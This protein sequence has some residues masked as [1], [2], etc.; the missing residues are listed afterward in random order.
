[1]PG[2]ISF[3]LAFGPLSDLP[4][5][6]HPDGAVIV[7]V[8][9][10]AVQTVVPLHRGVA[11]KL[12][13]RVAGQPLPKDAGVDALQGLGVGAHAVEH[14]PL[15]PGELV[16]HHAF[17]HGAAGVLAR[18]QVAEPAAAQIVDAD[19]VLA[20]AVV[21]QCLLVGVGGRVPGVD[22]VGVPLAGLVPEFRYLAVSFLIGEHLLKADEF[23]GEHRGDLGFHLAASLHGYLDGHGKEGTDGRSCPDLGGRSAVEAGKS[24]RKALR[25]LVAVAKGYVDDLFRPLLQVQGRLIEPAVPKVL[26][27]APAGQEGEAPLQEEGGEVYRPSHIVQ[28]DV[29]RQVLLHIRYRPADR[30]EP[31]HGPSP[32]L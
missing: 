19:A 17:G 16:E 32:F 30:G 22:V 15:S 25:G 2:G 7:G 27:H 3:L 28:A 5:H 9:F 18:D 24:L 6:R 26:A 4:L 13:V 20:D 21:H 10:L 14:G 8:I 12:I 29:L 1:M 11:A 23:E 31:F